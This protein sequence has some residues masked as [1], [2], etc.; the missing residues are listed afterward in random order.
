MNVHRH[1]ITAFTSIVLLSQSYQYLHTHEEG[2]GEQ[3]RRA[4]LEK[5]LEGG[6]APIRSPGST[7]TLC[8]GATTP[9]TKEELEGTEDTVT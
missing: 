1:H 5:L 7:A 4:Q 3:S 6:Q 8:R 9:H 2:M